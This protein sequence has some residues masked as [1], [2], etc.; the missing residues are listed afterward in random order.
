MPTCLCSPVFFVPHFFLK[1]CNCI[2][3]K[4]Q[5]YIKSLPPEIEHHDREE[6]QGVVGLRGLRVDVQYED[7]NTVQNPPLSSMTDEQLLKGK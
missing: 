5:N 3:G 1:D 2:A 4:L 7:D 6:L